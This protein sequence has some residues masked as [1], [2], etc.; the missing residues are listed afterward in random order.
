MYSPMYF[1]MVEFCSLVCTS[2]D[3]TTED[4]LFSLQVHVKAHAGHEGNEE[5][6]KLARQ[7]GKQYKS[8]A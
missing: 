1:S 6:D 8:E 7:G 2:P 5:A 3:T 4:V